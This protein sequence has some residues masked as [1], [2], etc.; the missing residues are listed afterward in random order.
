M[1]NPSTKYLNGKVIFWFII[2][3][4]LSLPVMII[5]FMPDYSTDP[6][7]YPDGLLIISEFG[8]AMLICA[9]TLAGIKLADDRQIL[10]AA[11]FTIFAIAQGII[12][13]TNFEMLGKQMNHEALEITFQMYVGSNFLFIPAIFLISTYSRFPKWLHYATLV[14]IIPYCVTNVLFLSGVRNIHLLDAVSSVSW[15]LQLVVY[16]FWGTIFYKD[17]MHQPE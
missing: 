16:I 15:L 2:L 4:T 5:F 14:S 7:T 9:A 8:S 3:Y 6:P 10:P 11:G 17:S 12:M 13:V 1:N